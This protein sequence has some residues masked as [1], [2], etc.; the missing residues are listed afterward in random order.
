LYG[1]VGCREIS[2]CERVGIIRAWGL[3]TLSS[4]IALR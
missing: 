2:S 3:G 4:V 1:S